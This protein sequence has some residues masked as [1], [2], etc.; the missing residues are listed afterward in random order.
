MRIEF[1]ATLIVL[2]IIGI[3][4]A[5]AITNKRLKKQKL[6]CPINDDCEKVV[7]S[8][9]SRMFL[10]KNDILGIFYYI[11]MLIITLYFFFTESIIAGTK[12]ISGLALIFSIFLVFVQA[13]ILKEYCF[14]CLVASFINLLI[15]I[16]LLVL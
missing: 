8:K 6:V 9:W 16:N 10:V 5:G 2:S 7:S 3:I 13:K 15:F 4:N 1:I 12:I 14:Y 11:F